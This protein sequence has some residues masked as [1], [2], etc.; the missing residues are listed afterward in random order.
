MQTSVSQYCT[1][2]YRRQPHPHDVSGGVS[3][4]GIWITDVVLWSSNE[5]DVTSAWHG[6][7]SA[8]HWHQD[9]TVPTEGQHVPPQAS[10]AGITAEGQATSGTVRLLHAAEGKSKW[11]YRFRHTCAEDW[12]EAFYSNGKS[13]ETTNA[14]L[15]PWKSAFC[16]KE[17]KRIRQARPS[18]CGHAELLRHCNSVH[19][20]NTLAVWHP[21]R[22][23][24][25]HC[26]YCRWTF[27]WQPLG[28]CGTTTTAH[29]H[30]FNWYRLSQSVD[31]SK[32]ADTKVPAVPRSEPHGLLFCG[33][34]WWKIFTWFPHR[35]T[36]RISPSACCRGYGGWWYV[37]T[38]F[39][40]RD[41][42]R[43]TIICASL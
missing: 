32:K 27:L 6:C 30:K 2:R 24:T 25:K 7:L 21:T 1:Q 43:R 3:T 12:R 37:N 9:T 16:A 22:S 26:Q 34:I 28:T 13:T 33:N 36:G 8:T 41:N 40:K 14:S 5:Y 42:V 18:V 39:E 10:N 31:R 17:R 19:C 29:N 38:T 4:L 15:D 11:T 23:S 35:N 20:L